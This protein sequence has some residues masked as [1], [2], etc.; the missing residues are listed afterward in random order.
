MALK[1][2]KVNA[3]SKHGRSNMCHWISAIEIKT[4]SKKLRRKEDKDKTK[5]T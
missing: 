2:V 4:S 3:G 5:F 1:K